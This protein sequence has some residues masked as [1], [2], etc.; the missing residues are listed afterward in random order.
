M[1]RGDMLVSSDNVPMI[2]RNFEAM[3]VWMDEENMDLE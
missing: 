1:S 3:L 2:D